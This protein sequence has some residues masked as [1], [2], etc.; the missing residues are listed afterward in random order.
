MTETL[1]GFFTENIKAIIPIYESINA[2]MMYNG[3]YIYGSILPA[4]SDLIEGRNL[5]IK[6]GILFTEKML[7]EEQNVVVLGFGVV[8]QNFP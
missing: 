4:S 8:S 7:L 5:K 3:Q 6:D 2:Q 1:R